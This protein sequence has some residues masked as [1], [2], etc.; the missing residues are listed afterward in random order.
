MKRHVQKMVEQ[1]ALPESLLQKLGDVPA[2]RSVYDVPLT[3][4][5]SR[6]ASEVGRFRVA[7]AE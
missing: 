1:G 2:A 3:I 6:P 4:V 7:R 5:K